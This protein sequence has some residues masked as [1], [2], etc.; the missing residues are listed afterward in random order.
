MRKARCILHFPQ[1]DFWPASLRF[2]TS[3]LRFQFTNHRQEMLDS[4]AHNE[5]GIAS[6]LRTKREKRAL[7]RFS[8]NVKNA[9][10]ASSLEFGWI[11][12]LPSNHDLLVVKI[13]QYMICLW[14]LLL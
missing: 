8:G 5:P 13:E 3:G 1:R 10:A 9:P 11:D 7:L 6:I 14:C 2:R 4:C 12:P